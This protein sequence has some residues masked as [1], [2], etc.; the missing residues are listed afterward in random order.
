M[1]CLNQ[2]HKEEAERKMQKTTE[3]RKYPMKS[4]D[5]AKYMKP[6]LKTAKPM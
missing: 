3:L 5:A 6:N 1:T 4:E 2:F